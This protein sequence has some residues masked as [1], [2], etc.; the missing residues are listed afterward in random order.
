MFDGV[1][2]QDAE[3]NIF[4]YGEGGMDL[5]R[6]WIKF[7]NEENQICSLQKYFLTFC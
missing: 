7:N 1:L 5:N 2:E 4:V 3:K 6:W